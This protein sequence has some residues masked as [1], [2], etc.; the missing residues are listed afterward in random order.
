[1]IE[2]I[3]AID[4]IDGKCVRLVQGDYQKKTVYSENPVEIAKSFEANGIKRLHLVDLDGAKSKHVVN[5]KTLEDIKNNTD[6][7]VDFGG[8]IKSDDDLKLVFASGAD[9]VTAGSIAVTNPSLFAS[10]LSQYGPEKIILGADT[11]EGKI[12]INGWQE[13]SDISFWDFM[14]ESIS[15]GVNY[16]ICTD[17]SRDGMLAGS[18][19]ELYEEMLNYYPTL[20]VIASGGINSIEEIKKLE[21]IGCFGA[22]IGKAIYEGWISLSDISKYISNAQ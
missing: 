9:Q 17:I 20:H 12:G 1:M 14:D 18:S 10:W 16:C 19:I 7:L 3:P 4:V 5:Y 6:L 2:I 15:Y 11:K 13:N 21:D 22:I 8:G